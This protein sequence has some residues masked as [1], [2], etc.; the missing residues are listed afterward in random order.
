MTR[1][2]AQTN[3]VLDQELEAVRRR[4]GLEPS[5]RADLLREVASLASWVLKQA[6]AGRSIE[7]R[8]GDEVEALEHPALE[9]LRSRAKHE[10]QR[11]LLS[12]EEV[13]RLARVF[14]TRFNPSPALRATLKRVASKKRRAPKIRWKRPAKAR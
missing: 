7:A 3:R 11:L 8:R 1:F 10:P 12:D 14:D 9:R 2:Q 5:Q 13:E 4:L 6:E